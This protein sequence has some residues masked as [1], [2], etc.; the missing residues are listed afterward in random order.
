M[1]GEN[2]EL[3]HELR[4]LFGRTDPVPEVVVEAGK[5]AWGWR[6]IDAD[7]AELLAD[8]AVDR[9][10]AGVRSG[11]AG[12]RHVTFETEETTIELEVSGEG[13]GHRILGHVSPGAGA[14]ITIEADDGR[15]AAS[16]TA[17]DLGRFDLRFSRAV[18][19]RMRVA[20][21]GKSVVSAWLP[22]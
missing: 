2:D 5:A 4:D 20:T 19:I 3:V 17:D 9:E 16:A 22:L 15:I 7:L 8:S 12:F 21:G 11:D 18:R 14:A 10:L 6:T 13:T 1:T